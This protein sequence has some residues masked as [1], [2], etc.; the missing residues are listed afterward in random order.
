MPLCNV[1][2][3]AHSARPRFVPAQSNAGF[4][5]QP[6]TFAR[7]LALHV[8]AATPLALAGI[9]LSLGWGLLTP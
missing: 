2:A 8:G 4:V 5:T 6:Q 7:M 9:G 3:Y 1:L